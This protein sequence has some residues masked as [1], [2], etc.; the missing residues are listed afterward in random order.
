MMQIKY[1]QMWTNN[2]VNQ[3]LPEMKGT[4]SFV[5]KIIQD[6]LVSHHLDLNTTVEVT[7]KVTGCYDSIRDNRTDF[8]VSLQTFPIQDY[9][10]VLPYQVLLESGLQIFFTL[11]FARSRSHYLC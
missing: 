8:A 7:S 6:Y 10:V 2:Q 3:G 1:P 4:V 5:S 11:Y 9:D